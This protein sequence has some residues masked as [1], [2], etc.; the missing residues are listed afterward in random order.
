MDDIFNI[1]QSIMT[2][3]ALL[4]ISIFVLPVV[5]TIAVVIISSIYQRKIYA[6]SEYFAATKTPYSTMRRDSG[7]YGEYLIYRQLTKLEGSKRFL[8]NSYL[9]KNDGTT[10]EVDV[11]LLH[12]S[13]IYVFESK[14]YSGWIFATETQTMW[15]QTF[16]NGHKEKFYNPIMQN[17]T[18]IKWLMNILPEVDKSI[19]HSIIVFSERC[20]LKKINLTTNDHIVLKRSYLMRTFVDKTGK[21]VLPDN[22]M[23]SIYQ[24]LYPFTQATESVKAAHRQQSNRGA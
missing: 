23:E 9:P 1:N 17:S 3:M 6:K 10:S 16:R 21:E 8:F 24:K 19:F 20:E 15:T 2:F 5:I 11:I 18:H 7:L 13:G 12:S 22:A 4:P 14:N